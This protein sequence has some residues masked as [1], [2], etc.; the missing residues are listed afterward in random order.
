MPGH[1]HGPCVGCGGATMWERRRRGAGNVDWVEKQRSLY[2]LAPP[3]CPY[4]P[5]TC[6]TPTLAYTPVYR[7]LSSWNFTA[8]AFVALKDGEAA[9][10]FAS[11]SSRVMPCTVIK[12]FND[13]G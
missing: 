2:R 12:V 3:T 9:V 6:P 13:E 5:H 1:R 7:L 4:L 11:T 8:S 10:I